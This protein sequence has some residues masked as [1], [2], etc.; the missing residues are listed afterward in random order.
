MTPRWFS[1][2]L[3][4]LIVGCTSNS[5]GLSTVAVPVGHTTFQLEVAKTPSELEKGLMERDSIPADHGMLFVFKEE[6]I[7]SFWMKNTRFD[8]DIIYLDHTDKVV[9][10]HQMKKYDLTTIS[11]DFPA[12]YAIEMNLGAASDAGVHVGDVIAIPKSAA[13]P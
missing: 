7:L 6:G 12:Q 2:S 9:S 13:A 11:S 8:M 4:L 3:L 10:I 5:G 1:L